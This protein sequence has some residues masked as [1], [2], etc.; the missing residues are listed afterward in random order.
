MSGIKYGILHCHTDNSIRD[1]VMTVEA[2]VTQAKKMGAPAVALTD[3]GVMTGYMEFM[4]LCRKE[5][6]NP[7][8]GVEA[9]VEEDVEG[10]RH[11][12]LMAK[13]Y[14]GFQALIKA[15]SESNTRI[16]K[17]DGVSCPRMNKDISSPAGNS[18][19]YWT[20]A[21]TGVLPHR[22]PAYPERVHS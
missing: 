10:C 22:P 7:I 5:G 12:I 16:A 6:I 11:L 15:V 2:L 13:D 4:K 1:S 17:V 9:Y 20:T 21:A 8:V 14:M 19:P 18:Y 3:H